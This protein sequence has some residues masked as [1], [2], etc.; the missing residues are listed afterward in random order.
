MVKLTC[1]MLVFTLLYGK[2]YATV[3]EPKASCLCLPLVMLKLTLLYGK[4]YVT[5]TSAFVLC[6]PF[7]L[8]RGTQQEQ[9]VNRHRTNREHGG[10]WGWRHPPAIGRGPDTD[11]PLHLTDIPKIPLNH[12][13]TSHANI[14][15]W[16]LL[17]RRRGSRHATICR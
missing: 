3:T 17:M 6:S 12:L 14:P 9:T 2:A 11:A 5:V 13:F 8:P 1:V 10:R 7:V 15:I 4:A 16:D